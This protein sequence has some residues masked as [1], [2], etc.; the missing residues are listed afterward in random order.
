VFNEDD[1][2]GVLKSGELNFIQ[3]VA[4]AQEFINHKKAINKR[5]Q[6]IIDA[7]KVSPHYDTSRAFFND[8]THRKVNNRIQ[9]WVDSIASNKQK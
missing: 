4:V 3:P 6:I 9:R 8:T 7:A 2:E 5:K 1:I